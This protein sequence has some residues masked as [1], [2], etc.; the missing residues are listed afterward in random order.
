ME[1]SFGLEQGWS[2]VG[3]IS[4]KAEGCW[5]E[6]EKVRS[7]IRRAGDRERAGESR[8]S[9]WGNWHLGEPWKPTHH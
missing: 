3:E 9:E 6:V 4:R 5:C 7:E 8:P 1:D 2:K